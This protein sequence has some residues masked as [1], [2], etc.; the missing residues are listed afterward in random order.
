MCQGA[1]ATTYSILLAFRSC[2]G[3]LTSLPLRIWQSWHPGQKG[4]HQTGLS[5]DPMALGVPQTHLP[6]FP[7]PAATPP[8]P[9]SPPG[10]KEPKRM[11]GAA[12]AATGGSK[13]TAHAISCISAYQEDRNG[14]RVLRCSHA[15]HGKR[16]LARYPP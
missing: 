15:L 2:P 11:T 14:D 6:R 9:P 16:Y 8:P 10:R 5:R 7:P 12:W 13:T 1:R 3:L 4:R